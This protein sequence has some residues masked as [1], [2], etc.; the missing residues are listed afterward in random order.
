MATGTENPARKPVARIAAALL[1]AALP[2]I[3]LVSLLLRSELDPHFENYRAHFVV[4]GIVGGVAFILGYTAGEAARMPAR[5]LRTGRY[6][7]GAL[8]GSAPSSVH[9]PGVK[10]P[11]EPPIATKRIPSAPGTIRRS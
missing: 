1:A 10:A 6:S 3:G 4:F 8:G 7:A 11:A 2:L 9:E 5:P